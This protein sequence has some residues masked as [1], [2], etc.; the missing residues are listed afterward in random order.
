[1]PIEV[2]APHS[3]PPGTPHVGDVWCSNRALILGYTAGNGWMSNVFKHIAYAQQG[4]AASVFGTTAAVWVCPLSQTW[5]V[6]ACTARWGTAS[7]SGTIDV[8]VTPAAIAPGS[9]T[10]Q[11]TATIDTSQAANTA[12]SVTMKALAARNVLSAG[13]AVSVVWGGDVTGLATCAITIELLRL[14]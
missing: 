11:T 7:T 12:L 4:L 10:S 13:Q 2:L 14:S 6:R 8:E 5:I 1:M 9:G 3:G